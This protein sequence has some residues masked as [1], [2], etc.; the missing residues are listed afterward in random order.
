M[1]ANF[2]VAKTGKNHQILS[3]HGRWL[4]KDWILGSSSLR[5]A[6]SEVHVIFNCNLFVFLLLFLVPYQQQKYLKYIQFFK[7]NFGLAFF[8]FFFFLLVW[9]IVLFGKVNG[10]PLQYSCLENSMNRRA[11]G[12]TYSPWGH[13]GLDMA[14]WLNTMFCWLYHLSHLISLYVLWFLTISSFSMELYPW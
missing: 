6:M 5:Q 4:Y 9:S 7:F 3:E 10:N 8:F 13:K 1:L 2:S 14:E 11:W 12:A